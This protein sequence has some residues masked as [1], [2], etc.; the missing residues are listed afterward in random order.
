ML[1][2]VQVLKYL[3][4]WSVRGQVVLGGSTMQEVTALL[5]TLG[6]RVPL[7]HERATQDDARVLE[8]PPGQNL[9]KDVASK[10]VLMN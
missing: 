7:V 1:L 8:E 10:E 2:P 4:S 6:V 3:L 9:E 5:F